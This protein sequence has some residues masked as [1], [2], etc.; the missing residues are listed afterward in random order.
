MK[1]LHSEYII[2]WGQG[3]RIQRWAGRHSGWQDCPK[4]TW[5]PEERYRLAPETV[6]YRVAL[7]K[8]SSGHH[9]TATVNDGPRAKVLENSTCFVRWI[10]DWCTTQTQLELLE[11]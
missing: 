3:K 10:T 9:Y 8:T 5:A 7:L 6:H 4:P 1:P 11:A 2:A